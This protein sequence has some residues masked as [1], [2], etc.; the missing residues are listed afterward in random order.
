MKKNKLNKQGFSF[1]E[2]VIAVSIL[3]FILVP[4][5]LIYS[6]F[7]KFYNYQQAKIKTGGTAREAVK[8]LQGAALQADQ[9]IT[10]HTFSGTVYSTDQ[11]T[12]VLEIPSVSSSGNIVNGK[13]DYAVFYTTGKNL[14]R[15]VQADAASSRPSGLNKISDTVSALTFTYNNSNLAQA[16]KIDADM[17]MQTTSGNQTVSSRLYQE[18][19]L[20]NK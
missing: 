7:S 18:I 15:L 10:S 20:R 8:E 14:Y 13:Y 4:L 5:S 6:G 16:N 1:I 9:I 19:Y 17:Q 3:I 12:V 2:T 11:H